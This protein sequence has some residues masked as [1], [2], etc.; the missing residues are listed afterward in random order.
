VNVA[1]ALARQTSLGLQ[2]STVADF[3]ATTTGWK[4]V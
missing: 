2:V 3:V 4:A 1:R